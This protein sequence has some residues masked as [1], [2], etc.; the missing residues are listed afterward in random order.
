MGSLEL[1]QGR[2]VLFGPY[3]ANF[4]DLTEIVLRELAGRQVQDAEEL[5]EA[6]AGLLDTPEERA[7]L[8]ERGR[9]LISQYR[10]ASDRMATRIADII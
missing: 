5:S 10:G 8:G 2:A 6:V 1:A 4:R 9:A 7:R 3:M